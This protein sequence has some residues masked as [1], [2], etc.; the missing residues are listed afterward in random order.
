VLPFPL[1]AYHSYSYLARA[2]A[3]VL[4]TPTPSH[5]RGVRNPHQRAPRILREGRHHLRAAAA[6]CLPFMHLCTP[7]PVQ[8]AF[9]VLPHRYASAATPTPTPAPTSISTLNLPTLPACHPWC[10]VCRP[11]PHLCARAPRREGSPRNRRGAEKQPCEVLFPFSLS[12]ASAASTTQT[13]PPCPIRVP[14]P[15]LVSVDRRG[16]KLTF[17]SLDELAHI[18]LNEYHLNRSKSTFI[19]NN[20]LAHIVLLVRVYPSR[21][22]LYRG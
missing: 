4:F 10:G 15:L 22:S 7:A 21:S 16:R 13:T 20:V 11:H 12:S 18:L 9:P 1:H 19:K 14:L 6:I 3:P 5:P 8:V 17:W 2:Y